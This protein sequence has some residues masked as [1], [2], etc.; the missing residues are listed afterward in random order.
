MAAPELKAPELYYPESDGKPMAE[1]DVHRDLMLDLI[2]AVAWRFAD[3]PEL[4]VSGNLFVYFEKGDVHKVVAPD[5]FVARG[6]PK[7]RRRIFKVW[8]ES[9]APELVIEL[10]S[11]STD[12]EDRG[13]KRAV[14]EQLGVKEYFIFDPEAKRLQV[15]A[16]RLKEG[17]FAPMEPVR[18]AKD[19]LVYRS[20]VLGLELHARVGDLRWVDPATGEVLPIPMEAYEQSRAAVELAEQERAKAEK[21]IAKAEEARAKAEEERAKADE[22]RAK[23]D[24]E[25]AR[26]D[27]EKARADRLEAELKKLR[28]GS[29]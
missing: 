20:G 23:A 18:R 26:A 5:F 29:A 8:E 14:Y 17:F 9:H 6:V 15:A 13:T 16:F 25:R 2:T 21:A 28:G 4:Y 22:A 1:T 24:E 19:V 7:H 27:R 10:T 3:D 12:L 11:R